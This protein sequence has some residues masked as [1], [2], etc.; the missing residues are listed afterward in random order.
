ML[1]ELMLFVVGLIL[2]PSKGWP[3]FP[4]ENFRTDLEPRTPNPT[5]KEMT[6]VGTK[7]KNSEDVERPARTHKERRRYVKSH[8]MAKEAKLERFKWMIRVMQHKKSKELLE[9]RVFD[10]D[11]MCDRVEA[12]RVQETNRNPGFQEC[13][14][15]CGRRGVVMCKYR[16]SA[17][18]GRTPPSRDAKDIRCT[19]KGNPM[20][21][22]ECIHRHSDAGAYEG[23][24]GSDKVTRCDMCD[25]LCPET[26]VNM[27]G[28]WVGDC[29]IPGLFK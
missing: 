6:I 7:S 26:I 24:C 27:F 8:R 22:S 14:M 23:Q 1:N 9:M 5:P 15:N 17:H 2:Q 18:L 21:C 11:E 4:S 16:E 13:A 12:R 20:F 28:I 10:D 29:C 19:W 25:H 3:L